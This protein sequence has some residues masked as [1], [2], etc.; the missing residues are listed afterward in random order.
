MRRGRKREA[1]K[2]VLIKTWACCFFIWSMSESTAARVSSSEDRT[3]D[4]MALRR[5]GSTSPA[6]E[7]VAF[8]I[9]L[10]TALIPAS[11]ALSFPMSG[12]SPPFSAF[13]PTIPTDEDAKR[14][15]NNFS[16]A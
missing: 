4:L 13:R 15:Y 14:R 6:V 3:V 9:S 1:M 7:L 16:F 10:A 11:T 2:R 8:S 12:F 5:R